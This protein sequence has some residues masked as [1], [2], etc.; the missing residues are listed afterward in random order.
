MAEVTRCRHGIWS[1]QRGGHEC[2]YAVP[3]PFVSE[4]E[5]DEYEAPRERLAHGGFPGIPQALFD[6]HE[7][8]RDAHG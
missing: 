7:E 1:D 3:T 8:D 2:E 6:E 4:P 5:P